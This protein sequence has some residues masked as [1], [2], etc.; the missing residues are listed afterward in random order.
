MNDFQAPAKFLTWVLGITLSFWAVGSLGSTTLHMA[1]AAIQ[2]QQH[3]Q[4][5][6][7]KGG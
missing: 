1:E 7:Y 5:L 6:S 4:W 3:D 2:A